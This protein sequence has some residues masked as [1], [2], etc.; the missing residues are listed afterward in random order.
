MLQNFSPSENKENT[1]IELY[2][3]QINDILCK[4]KEKTFET[5]TVR[6]SQRKNE[7]VV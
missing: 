5:K 7:R 4:A 3:K 6:F 1:E 2:I